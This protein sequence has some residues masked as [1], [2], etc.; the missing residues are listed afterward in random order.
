MKDKIIDHHEKIIYYQNK[1][2]NLNEHSTEYHM[3]KSTFTTKLTESKYILAV[4]KKINDQVKEEDDNCIICFDKLENPALTP[5]GHLFCH[6]C[7]QMCI[8]SKPQC[9]VCKADLKIRK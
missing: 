3:L 5:C 4:L 7:L 6:E 1:L 2:E 8:H 9:P